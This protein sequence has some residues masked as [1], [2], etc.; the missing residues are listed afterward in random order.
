MN[1]KI[2][3]LLLLI[4]I[5]SLNNYAQIYGP[6]LISNGNFGTTLEGVNDSQ[7]LYPTINHTNIPPQYQ[8]P[9]TVYSN[10]TIQDIAI[11]P[12]VVVGKPIPDQTTYIWG[13]NEPWANNVF[14]FVNN[15]GQNSWVQ[16]PMAPNNGYYSI[17]TATNGMY[18][19]PTLTSTHPWYQI[20]DR[21]ETNEANPTNYFM[22]IN[23]DADNQKIFYKQAVSVQPGHIYRMSADISRLNIGAIAPN[24]SFI[25]S[26]NDNTLETDPEIFRSGDIPDDGG[27]WHTRY[28]DYVAPCN[29]DGTDNAYTVWVAFRN[30]ALGT[31]GN[32]LALDN[33]SLRELQPQILADQDNGCVNS[34]SLSSSIPGALQGGNYH[35]RWF[36]NGVQVGGDAPTLTPTVSGDY[37]VEIYY[38]D[39]TTNT[40]ACPLR[41][42]T[43][44]VTSGSD[45]SCLQIQMPCANDDTYESF[46]GQT[47]LGN[48]LLNDCNNTID[49]QDGSTT[50]ACSQLNLSVLDYTMTQGNTATTYPAGTPVVLYDNDNNKIGVVTID[51]NGRIT[52]Q[53]TPDYAGNFIDYVFSYRIIN[54]VNGGQATA[55]V[56]IDLS[57]LTY[58]VDATCNCYPVTIRL[59]SRN[60]DTGQGLTNE[61]IAAQ[62]Y[63]LNNNTDE[64]YATTTPGVTS[65]F[66]PAIDQPT[67]GI[68]T[69][70]F[71]EDQSGDISYGFY[72]KSPE[73]APNPATDNLLTTLTASIS[74]TAATWS[75]TAATQEWNESNNWRA[76]QMGGYP[77]WCTDVIIP[78]NASNYPTIV[79]NEN[80]CRDIIFEPGASVGQIQNLVYRAAYVEYTPPSNDKWTMLSVPLKYVYSADFQPDPSWGANA[81]TD[82]KSYMSY[83]DIGYTENKENPD[84][85][86]STA[87]GNFSLPFAN[88]TEGL[89]TGF[90][91][92][93]NVIPANGG[94]TTYNNKFYFPRLNPFGNQT[95]IGQVTEGGATVE[96]VTFKYHYKDNGEWIDDY[97]T[98]PTKNPFTIPNRGGLKTDSATWAN[99]FLSET[100]DPNPLVGQDSRYRFIYETSAGAINTFSVTNENGG[101]TR[102][103]GNPFMSHLDFVALHT[104]ANNRN[105]I[106]P[107]FRLWDG[108]N[109]YSYV[110]E[111]EDGTW[112][113][114]REINSEATTAAG[115]RYIAP[116]QAFFVE[117]N[118][119]DDNLTLTFNPVDVSV[120]PQEDELSRSQLKSTSENENVLRIYLLMN[121]QR[122]ASILASLPKGTDEY[123]PQED[124]YK[125]FSYDR[126]TP[127]I[128]TV[129]NHTALEINAVSQSGDIKSVPL[130]IKTNHTGPFSLEIE[131]IENFSAYP[132][133]Y[134]K[135]AVENKTYDLKENSSLSFTKENSKNIEGRF[136]IIM[137]RDFTDIKENAETDKGILVSVENRFV[138]VSSPVN[139]FHKIELLD[140]SGRLRYLNNQVNSSYYSFDP[141][142]DSG[143]YI[144]KIFT[145]GGIKIQKITL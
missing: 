100:P 30:Y 94:G 64:I 29:P 45:P 55:N 1:T 135:D 127:E 52:F 110:I 68:Q 53:A 69:I 139:T 66:L 125:L 72:K 7:D 27:L 38:I 47:T 75:P 88:L 67:G 20:Y 73:A 114:L 21:Y 80:Q 144:I 76:S 93:L 70:T 41:T 97:P 142:V 57:V 10:G 102:L 13:F 123:N 26:P 9:T 112:E 62:H 59:S 133:L 54:T 65:T 89:P 48:V 136:Y 35:F 79:A 34:L 42:S 119:P 28:F 51:D 32:D 46:P 120:A 143:I 126:K 40:S 19:A 31:N 17:V 131:G 91:F 25:I 107:Y 4:F 12:Y 95:E 134:L 18:A 129:A 74:P 16:I 118:A 104:H 50:P 39:E 124:I 22:L 111:G 116:M 15:T 101:T 8:P 115:T 36:A 99:N 86:T 49:C 137:T 141:S 96:E 121:D 3:I 11:N 145:P 87:F 77:I 6:E 71:M 81:F 14:T 92:A 130:G 83:F 24:I 108:T 117:T 90:G 60:F 140:A 109:F 128:Y 98:D 103:I 61:Q 58:Q 2:K 113:G 5:S 23:A 37:Y 78:G 105:L 138:T 43:I 56:T 44:S 132:G 122:N 84:G 85:V 63:L 33:L 82:M 106:F